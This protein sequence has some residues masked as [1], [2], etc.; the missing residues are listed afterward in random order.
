MPGHHACR[1]RGASLLPVRHRQAAG[2]CLRSANRR[3]GLA[4]AR[5]LG[6][7][8]Y[9]M[10]ARQN[11]PRPSVLAGEIRVDVARRAATKEDDIAMI[12]GLARGLVPGLMDV[13][14]KAKGLLPAEYP[15]PGE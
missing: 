3:R 6:V 12:R 9:S 7:W 5:G 8:R 13:I 10:A 11:P 4:T 14:R 1:P 2:S 15:E